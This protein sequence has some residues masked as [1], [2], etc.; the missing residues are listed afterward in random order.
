MLMAKR[1]LG[2]DLSDET[3]DRFTRYC[4]TN[5]YAKSNLATAALRLI[6]LVPPDIRE[7]ALIGQEKR[8]Q[9][10]FEDATTRMMAGDVCEEWLRRLEER[11]G[12]QPKK[13]SSAK[14]G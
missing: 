11:Q 4:E 8:L 12:A 3:V 2:P 7:L 1:K 5:G 9:R 13:G 14:T 6:E 10:W